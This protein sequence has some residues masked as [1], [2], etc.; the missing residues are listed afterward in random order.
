MRI[1]PVGITLLCTLLLYGCASSGGSQSPNKSGTITQA[2]IEATGLVFSSAHDVVR[3]L[4]PRWLIKRGISTFVPTGVSDTLL[5][6]IAVYIDNT[7]MGDPE[8]LYNVSP[9][10]IRDIRFLD[11]AQAQRL[12]S[13]SHIHGAIVVRTRA[14]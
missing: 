8:T 7:L 1:Y 5:D 9:L 11:T 14:R 3:Q 13:R 6:F 12:G 2:E 4:R 10:L